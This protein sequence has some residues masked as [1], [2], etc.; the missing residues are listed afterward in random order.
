MIK[1]RSTTDTYG[2]LMVVGD[3]IYLRSDQTGAW[4]M[5]RGVRAHTDAQLDQLA[6]DRTKALVQV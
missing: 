6:A 4:V 2:T 1:D 3:S 5:F